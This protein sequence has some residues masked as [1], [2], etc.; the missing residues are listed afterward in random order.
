MRCTRRSTRPPP[1]D[2]TP[3][4][5]RG[6]TSPPSWRSAADAAVLRRDGTR[7]IV[8][9]DDRSVV[10]P[11]LVGVGYLGDLL[12]RPGDEIDAVDLCRG[13]TVEGVSQ[14]LVDRT[15]LDVYRRRVVEID[16]LLDAARQ[17]R[18]DP[19]RRAPRGRARRTAP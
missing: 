11:D 15:T 19:P 4:P 12:A 8:D 6:A 5:R 10:V 18:T 16:R 9:V 17:H 13:T 14:D 3:A 2:W 1:S 7:W